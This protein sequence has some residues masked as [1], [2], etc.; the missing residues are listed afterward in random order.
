MT[1]THI[2]GSELGTSRLS[3]IVP[4]HGCRFIGELRHIGLA[5][6]SI[7]Q[8]YAVAHAIGGEAVRDG[9]TG[10]NAFARRAPPLPTLGGMDCLKRPSGD[11][12]TPPS[13]NQIGS[14]WLPPD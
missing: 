11:S 1:R 7:R 12:R 2:V 13:R 14:M 6:S 8:T 4:A 5:S 10:A 3:A 9:L